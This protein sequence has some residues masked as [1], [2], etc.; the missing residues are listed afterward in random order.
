[1]VLLDNIYSFRVAQLIEIKPKKSKL[2][3]T[4]T[5]TPKR[6]TSAN[7]SVFPLKQYPI[8]ALFSIYYSTDNRFLLP[9]STFTF[10]LQYCL[11]S[12]THF[13]PRPTA[14]VIMSPLL[15]TLSFSLSLIFSRLCVSSHYTLFQ[16]P[17]KCPPSLGNCNR[18][19]H[20]LCY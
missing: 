5:T 19:V 13:S 12:R 20:L 14:D 2:R 11:C 18:C 6:S 3:P 15:S 8:F 1:M 17:R 9:L 4:P 10:K 16:T 7:F